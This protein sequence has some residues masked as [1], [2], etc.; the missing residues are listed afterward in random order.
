MHFHLAASIN[1]ETGEFYSLVFKNE[2][3]N[4]NNLFLVSDIPL[5]PS[6]ITDDPEREPN[7]ILHW[8]NNKE[9]HFTMQAEH[10]LQDLTR[11]VVEKEEGLQNHDV[12]HGEHDSEDEHTPSELFFFFQSLN[13][14]VSSVTVFSF[15]F[16]FS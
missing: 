12:E 4:N 11:K 15:F 10:I 3:S 8:L 6:L 1:A 14:F 7:F 16:L 2:M 9:M 5:V 13:N